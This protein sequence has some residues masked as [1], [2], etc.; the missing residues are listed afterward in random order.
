M[1]GAKATRVD[2][3]HHILSRGIFTIDVVTIRCRNDRKADTFG[4]FDGSFKLLTLNLESIVHDFDEVAFAEKI[5]KPLSHFDRIFKRLFCAVSTIVENRFTEFARHT[6]AQADDP[7]AVS[8]QQ[9]LV[10]PR[11]KVETLKRR[12]GSHFDQVIETGFVL[13]KQ[14]QVIG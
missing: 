2:T 12:R 8:F 9:F 13:A 10:D 4:D 3:Q 1:V 6:T 5:A 14:R 7:F 11:L